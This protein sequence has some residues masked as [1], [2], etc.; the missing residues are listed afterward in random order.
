MP[1]EEHVPSSQRADFEST[2]NQADT[3]AMDLM[4]EY[5]RQLNGETEAPIA[6]DLESNQA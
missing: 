6:M 2:L 1:H 3:L 4:R 5:A